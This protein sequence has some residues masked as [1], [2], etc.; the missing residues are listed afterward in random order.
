MSLVELILRFSQLKRHLRTGWLT[1]GIGRGDVESIAEHTL[2]TA[3]IA[4]LLVDLETPKLKV[5]SDLILRM[6]IIH[7]LPEVILKDIDK[8]AW[9]YLSPNSKTKRE[10]EKA[11]LADLFAEIPAELRER[12][13]EIWRQYREGDSVETKIVE[14][15]DKLEMAF[16]AYEYTQLG[17]PGRLTEDMWMDAEKKICSLELTSARKLLDE[18][19]EKMR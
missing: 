18:L 10:V 12:Y 13:W 9:S 5:D 11:V 2:R 8:E 17:Y 1:K 16:Q 7:D 6:A 19:K 4:M 14:A 15:A 3:F